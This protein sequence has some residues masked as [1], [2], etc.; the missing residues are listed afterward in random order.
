MTFYIGIFC[1]NCKYNLVARLESET[2]VF[3]NSFNRFYLSPSAGTNEKILIFKK[4]F[5]TDDEIEF[6]SVSR[7]NGGKGSFE[8]KMLVA[9]GNII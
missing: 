2:E 1:V 3:A 6:R 4:D 8:F 7:H 9:K 5:D